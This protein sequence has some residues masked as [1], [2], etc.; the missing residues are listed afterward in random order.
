VSSVTFIGDRPTKNGGK[1][2]CHPHIDIYGDGDIAPAALF[3]FIHE[4]GLSVGRLY[5]QTVW[6]IWAV[7][8]QRGLSDPTSTGHFL[9]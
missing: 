8:R 3:I 1:E 6:T 4:L 5:A 9:N 7:D 2:I